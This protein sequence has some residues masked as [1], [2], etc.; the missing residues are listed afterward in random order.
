MWRLLA[1]VICTEA[2]ATAVEFRA[3]QE[4]IQGYKR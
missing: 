3:T 1:R 4:V 2:I